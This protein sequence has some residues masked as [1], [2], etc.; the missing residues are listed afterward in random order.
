MTI[1]ATIQT[2]KEIVAVLMVLNKKI[3]QLDKPTSLYGNAQ[4][5]IFT[6]L[7]SHYLGT[8]LAMNKHLFA[9]ADMAA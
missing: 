3:E 4:L 8:L 5:T 1:A 6:T 2:R 7:R 9:I